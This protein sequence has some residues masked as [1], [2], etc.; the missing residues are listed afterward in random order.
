[1]TIVCASTAKAKEENPQNA[2]KL[3]ANIDATFMMNLPVQAAFTSA[4]RRGRP[5]ERH[6]IT[7]RKIS[8]QAHGVY[9]G[10]EIRKF[11]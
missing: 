2:I 3:S 6:R 9:S 10:A 7:P 11:N 4:A 1:V 5:A 8:R